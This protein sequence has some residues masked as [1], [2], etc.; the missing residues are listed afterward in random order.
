V[1]EGDPIQQSAIPDREAP[2]GNAQAAA[3][4]DDAAAS[5]AAREALQ[6]AAQDRINAGR[7]DT[8]GSAP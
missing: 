5:V 7:H 4:S 1:A 8:I 2:Y 6:A 3:W